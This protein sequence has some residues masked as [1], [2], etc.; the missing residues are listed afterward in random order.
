MKNEVDYIAHITD[1]LQYIPHNELGKEASQSR[2][3]EKLDC[4][5]IIALVDKTTG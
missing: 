5:V 3:L 4:D 1:R 2:Q